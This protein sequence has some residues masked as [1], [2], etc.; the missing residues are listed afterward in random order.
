MDKIDQIIQNFIAS[1]D[2]DVASEMFSR[3][4]SGKKL[5]SK[6]LLNIAGENEQTLTLCAIAELIQAAS[7]LHDDVIDES[8]MRR[9]KASINAT[10]GSKNAVM[11][12]DILYSKAYNELC[13][14]PQ[15]VADSLSSAVTKLAIGELMDVKMSERFNTDAAAYRKMIY[16]KTAGRYTRR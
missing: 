5:R 9:G 11:L 2:Y 14:F 3:L 10:Y 6:L 12:G 15:F 16:Y 4:S 8:T 13:K 7:L 1:C